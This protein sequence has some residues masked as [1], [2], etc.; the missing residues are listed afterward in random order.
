MLRTRLGVRLLKEN[1]IRK[2]C[3]M[4][5]YLLADRIYPE[6]LTVLLDLPHPEQLPRIL[7]RVR[8]LTTTQYNH[9]KGTVGRRR[10]D[11]GYEALEIPAERLRWVKERIAR[12]RGVSPTVR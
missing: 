2:K 9:L 12:G 4:D 5:A 3:L 7:H 11:R 6:G 10:W 1:L 8:I